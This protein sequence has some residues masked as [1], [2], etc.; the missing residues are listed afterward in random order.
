MAALNRL[1]W[2]VGGWSISMNVVLSRLFPGDPLICCGWSF[3][4]F[5]TRPLSRW[6]KL[7]QLQL[8]VPNPMVTRYGISA[9]GRVSPRTASNVG[10]RRFLVVEQDSGAADLQASM[11]LHL[12]QRAPLALV[13]HSG[14]KSLHGWFF[15]EGQQE[16]NLRQFM[17]YAVSIGADPMTWTPCQFVRMPGGT[18]ET[19]EVQTILYFRPDVI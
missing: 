12:A 3:R 14:R 7:E 11:L 17:R 9:A 4:R 19:G 13:V 6:Y 5:D 2:A 8:I 1:P 18:R 10:S 15:C 16:N